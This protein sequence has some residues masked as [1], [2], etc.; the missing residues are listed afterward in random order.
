MNP[1]D[2]VAFNG[3]TKDE[4]TSESVMLTREHSCAFLNPIRG[5]IKKAVEKNKYDWQEAHIDES[6]NILMKIG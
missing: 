3:M 1:I 6:G 5:L 2:F 4:E